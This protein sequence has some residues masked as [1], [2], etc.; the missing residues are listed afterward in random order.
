VLGQ[1]ADADA[2]AAL[3]DFRRFPGWMW[4][5]TDIAAF[6]GWL[7][8]YND[9]CDGPLRQ[10][11][12]YGLD[13]YSLRAS[14]EAVVAYL[15]ANDAAAAARARDR[16]SCF[17]HVGGE[18]PDYGNAVRLDLTVPC[19]REVIAELVDLRQ[20]AA[21]L[22]ASDG[23]AAADEYFV[24]SRTLESSTTRALLP[25]D[26]PGRVSS[27]NLRD[28]HMAATLANLAP[29]STSCVVGRRSWSGST[30][31]MWATPRATELGQAG[32]FNVASWCGPPGGRT[33][34]GRI[35][36]RPRPGDRGVRVG[37]PGRAKTRA[38][39]TRGQLREALP[40]GTGEKLLD[41]P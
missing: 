33:A 28:E 26:V 20:H 6:I 3:A 19:E 29:T 31:R 22:M 17:D 10:V 4:R 14:M 30:T 1:S 21:A 11:R 39:R 37:R 36:H 5:N 24:P 13:L 9:A 27:W 35:H 41:V 23:Q 2:T 40:P 25:G 8:S 16:F 12:F 7:R 15:D 34:A 18:G 32:E 38:T